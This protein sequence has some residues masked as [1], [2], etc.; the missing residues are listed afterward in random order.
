MWSTNLNHIYLTSF[1]FKVKLH[2]T[3]CPSHIFKTL[4]SKLVWDSLPGFGTVCEN[5]DESQL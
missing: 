3:Q 1:I 5:K 4:N 2:N